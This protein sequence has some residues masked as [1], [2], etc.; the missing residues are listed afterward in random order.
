MNSKEEE[1]QTKEGRRQ[2]QEKGFLAT[3]RGFFQATKENKT[4]GKLTVKQQREEASA[5]RRPTGYDRNRSQQRRKLIKAQKQSDKQLMDYQEDRP[6]KKFSRKVNR[7]VPLG[8]KRLV[9][10]IPLKD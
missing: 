1:P 6:R 2:A 4:I 5:S 10:N 3:L 9:H 8:S 7:F